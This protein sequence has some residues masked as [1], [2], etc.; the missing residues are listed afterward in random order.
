MPDFRCF[1]DIQAPN[2]RVI[3]LSVEESQ[4]LV[5]ANRA[6]VGDPVVAFTGDG[7]EFHARVV[8]ANRRKTVLSVDRIETARPPSYTIALAQ[9]LPK[10]KLFENIIKKAAEIGIQRLYPLLTERVEVKL[11]S[12]KEA[13]KHH[14]WIGA[15]IEG[16]KQSGNPFLPDIQE[17]TDLAAFLTG[18]R[19]YEL[20]LIASLRPG[21][22]SLKSL[23]DDYRSQHGGANPQ[24]VVW[25]VGP[26][27]DFTED[28]LAAAERAGFQH[29][30]LG[31]Y[32]MRCETAAVAA[33]SIIRHE[34][35]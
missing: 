33:L 20:R 35:S 22:R 7:L 2:T 30:T 8:E 25:V 15:A 4:H 3:T 11:K 29:A 34:L 9:A 17:P 19:D 28:E 27:G 26:E 31:P 13:A 12:E 23:L 6:R 21:A 18:L 5:A 32:V 10:G 14:K 16:S 1:C 24:S